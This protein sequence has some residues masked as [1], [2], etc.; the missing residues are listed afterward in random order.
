VA[1]VIEPVISAVNLIQIFPGVISMRRNTAIF[2]SGTLL[3]C[4]VAFYYRQQLQTERMRTGQISPA[5][6]QVVETQK[7]E[8]SVA[9]PL[10]PVAVAPPIPLTENSQNGQPDST[11]AHRNDIGLDE[12]AAKDPSSVQMR[13]PDLQKETGFSPGDIESLNELYNKRAWEGEIEA[14]LGSAKYQRLRDYWESGTG[15]A[16][17]SDLRRALADTAHPLREDQVPLL[18]S[19][20]STEEGRFIDEMKVR[21]YPTS[22]PKV[23]LDLQILVAKLRQ[24]HTARVLTAASSYLGPEQMAVLKSQLFPEL[25]EHLQS[26]KKQRSE[27]K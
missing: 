16:R 18:Y 25:E 6:M 20:I 11:L 17:I 13:Y 26:L 4:A 22:D 2:L 10:P 14:R 21:T 8:A 19:T 15:K 1:S 9:P 12:D 23:V 24:E 7:Q 3:A 27:L 5:S